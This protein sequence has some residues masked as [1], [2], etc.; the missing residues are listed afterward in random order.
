MPAAYI[1]IGAVVL[2]VL[3]ALGKTIR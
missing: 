1:A 2:L 3:I